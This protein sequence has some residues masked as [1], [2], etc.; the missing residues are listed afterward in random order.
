M[1]SSFFEV[2]NFACSHFVFYAACG[3]ILIAAQCTLFISINL[4]GQ[5]LNFNT[6]K[7]CIKFLSHWNFKP[8]CAYKKSEGPKYA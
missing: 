6:A 3:W 1:H 7:F 2:I 4:L 8:K 5:L